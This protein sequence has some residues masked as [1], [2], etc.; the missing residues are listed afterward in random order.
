MT[1]RRGYE[2]K[3]DL[4]RREKIKCAYLYLVRG[5]PQTAQAVS[6]ML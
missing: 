5:V 6:L 2:A 4:T 1:E 3:T